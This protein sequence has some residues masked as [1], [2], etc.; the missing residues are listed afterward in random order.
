MSVTPENNS[1]K[2]LTDHVEIVAWLS[3]HATKDLPILGISQNGEVVV[4][5]DIFLHLGSETFIP[6]QFIRVA[7]DFC[8]S[9]ANLQSL[10]GCPQHC[11]AF[12]GDQL[13]ALQNLKGGPLIC[14]TTYWVTAPQLKSL[15]GAPISCNN[16]IIRD[17]TLTSWDHCPDAVNLDF[18][19]I[20]KP[21]ATRMRQLIRATSNITISSQDPHDGLTWYNHLW[22]FYQDRD[23]LK[24]ANAFE[25][26]YGEPLIVSATPNEAPCPITLEKLL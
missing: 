22:A 4:D 1:Q 6:V 10:D 5:G 20:P 15:E 21:T 3:A 11:A 14:D 12:H 24:M 7:G 25:E 26:L 8:I 2:H 23:L 19:N 9:G 18:D 16:F 17:C 13:N